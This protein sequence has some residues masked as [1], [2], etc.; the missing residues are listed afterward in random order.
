VQN[1]LAIHM[2]CHFVLINKCSS[3]LNR[4]I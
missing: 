3:I 2:V 4:I 1:R